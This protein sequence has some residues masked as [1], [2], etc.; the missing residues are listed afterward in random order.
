MQ[1]PPNPHLVTPRSSVVL[2]CPLVNAGG[3]LAGHLAHRERIDTR[4]EEFIKTALAKLGS[5]HLE[6]WGKV[7]EFGHDSV[8][9][10]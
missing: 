6:Q 10:R 7:S 8:L 5:G 1:H 3:V 4:F 2:L 9:I